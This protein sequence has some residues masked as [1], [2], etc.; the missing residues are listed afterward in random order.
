MSRNG[1]SRRMKQDRRARVL[2]L[3]IETQSDRHWTPDN[4]DFR[5]KRRE[6]PAPRAVPLT[7]ESLTQRH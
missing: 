3:Q 4:G 2:T 7:E 6:T 5:H 1:R